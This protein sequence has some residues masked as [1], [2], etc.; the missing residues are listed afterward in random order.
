MPQRLLAASRR[1][2]LDE[3]AEPPVREATSEPLAGEAGEL[4][5]KSVHPSVGRQLLMQLQAGHGNAYV[6]RM[7]AL[8]AA[9]GAGIARYKDRDTAAESVGA[10]PQAAV[11]IAGKGKRAYELGDK[12]YTDKALE[13]L[14]E[15]AGG[16]FASEQTQNQLLYSVQPAFADLNRT[17]RWMKAK[18][19]RAGDNSDTSFGGIADRAKADQ[20]GWI[21]AGDRLTEAGATEERLCKEFNAGIPRANR[22]FVSLSK[23]DG[24]IGLLGVSDPKSM[25]TAVVGSLREAVPVVEALKATGKAAE[26]KTV[27]AATD[28]ATQAATDVTS[29]Q[30]EMGN[31]WIG[32]QE[33][34]EL[35]RAAAVLKE[36]EADEKELAAIQKDIA[37]MRNAGKAI[38]ASMAVMGVGITGKTEGGG[39]RGA[40]SGGGKSLDDAGEWSGSSIPG[41]LKEAGK[42][43]GDAMGLEIPTSASGIL[44]TAAKLYHYK[45]L[46]RIRFHLAVLNE[47]A[48]AHRKVA[49]K[50]GILKK[51]RDFDK[52]FKDFERSQT[53]LLN[54]LA[55]RQEAYVTFGQQLDETAA[56]SVPGEAPGRGKER[57]T[58]VMAVTALAREVLVM[59]AGAEEGLGTGPDAR[60]SDKL[61]VEFNKLWDINGWSS[62]Y[63]NDSKALGIA[64]KQ[65]RDFDARMEAVRGALGEIDTAASELLGPMV[66]GKQHA[67]Y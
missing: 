31:A 51:L 62:H 48:A 39:L 17:V 38:D 18:A 40:L 2:D 14:P 15:I 28:S 33:T 25:V 16:V 45:E 26:K 41:G 52:A 65:L 5:F 11:A 36:G 21:A 24:M 34:L 55:A 46:E 60:A 50:L 47:H 30:E 56:K 23:L 6:S 66:G 59:A 58:T 20:A 43:I 32:V 57:F 19:Q 63:K 44:E 67:M 4:A 42:G 27:P 29:A 3:V 37:L 10:D 54:A 9:P 49:E 13:A 12:G 61:Q 22:V 64:L 35:D 7:A 1:R 8:T 53:A